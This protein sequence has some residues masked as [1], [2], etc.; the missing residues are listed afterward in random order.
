[1]RAL[2]APRPAGQP[3]WSDLRWGIAGL[4]AVL[5]M[6]AGVGVAFVVQTGVHTYAADMTDAGA[7]R[8]GDE[9]RVA[10]VTVGKVKSLL[11]HPGSVRMTFT[12][13]DGV[14][15]GT[16]STLAVRMLT[17]VG[18]HYVALIPAGD[19]PLGKAIIAADRVVLPYSL[20]EVFQDAVKPIENID[21]DVFRQNLAAL[22]SAVASSPKSVSTAVTAVDSM[23]SIM[24]RQNADVSR[25][26]KVADEYVT[27]IDGA[28]PVLAQAIN[29]LNVVE[30]LVLTNIAQVGASLRN[31]AAV[32]D[33][34]APLGRE[35]DT[36]L[37][38]LVQQLR[39]SI[40]QLQQI[41]ADFNQ[42]LRAL[43]DLGH[44]LTPL[45]AGSD[46]APLA[47]APCIPMAG[48]QC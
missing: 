41:S 45:V 12:V 34:L 43:T 25:T 38:P 24:N 20:T 40:P 30:N 42:F 23:V 47:V 3:R 11:L 7:V 6:L 8:S 14:F 17:I 31:L 22:Q 33:R 29:S 37:A 13:D 26:L 27:A 36:S 46:Q 2:A 21:G 32:L 1:M 28:K 9:I 19:E 48:R 16:Q 44:T 4:S 18:G 10:G 15:V 5:I 39:D 35:W